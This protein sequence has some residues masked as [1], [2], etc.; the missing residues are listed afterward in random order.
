MQDVG[1]IGAQ[2]VQ[3]YEEL[4]SQILS[5]ADSG[6]GVELC[7]DEFVV[8]RPLV[9][10]HSTIQRSIIEPGTHIHP[11]MVRGDQIRLSHHSIQ[12]M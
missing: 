2:K 7:G 6:N 12:P 5:R 3:R 4:R 1:S 10:S 11:Q 8:T 9:L